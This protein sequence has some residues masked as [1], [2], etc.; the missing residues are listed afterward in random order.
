MYRAGARGSFDSLAI[1]AYATAP[2]LVTDLVRVAR[3]ALAKVGDPTLPIRVTET[4]WATAGPASQS[5]NVGRRAQSSL[6]RATLARFVRARRRLGVRSVTLFNFSNLPAYGGQR[7]YWGLYA[8]LVERDGR[9]KPAL[10][11]FTKIVRSSTRAGAL[12]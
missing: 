6:V 5:L 9:P 2:D 1:H 8:G 4:G 3:R 10:R 12:S 11:A 7:D